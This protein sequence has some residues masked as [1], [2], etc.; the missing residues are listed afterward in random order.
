M[1]DLSR[2]TDTFSGLFGQAA[3]AAS[4][5]TGLA[6]ILARNGLDPSVLEGLDQTQI[7]DLLAGQGI[8]L[9]SLA[10]GELAGVLE[11]FG[12]TGDLPVG[13]DNIGFNGGDR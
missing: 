4:S 12:I 6:D 8:D 10:P 7:M 2:L 11:Q 5:A 1:F 13:L 9:A 3:E